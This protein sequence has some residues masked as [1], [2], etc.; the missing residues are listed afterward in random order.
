M[1]SG[2][3]GEPKAHHRSLHVGEPEHPLVR[4][5]VG[6]RPVGRLLA[7]DRTGLHER[8]PA[9]DPNCRG[10]DI[11][12]DPPL[13]GLEQ[14]VVVQLFLEAEV[15]VGI[16][17]DDDGERRVLGGGQLIQPPLD[18]GS[19][20]APVEGHHLPVEVID[21]AEP[22]V[23]LVG[24]LGEAHVPVEGTLEQGADRRGLEEDVRLAAGMQV[25]MPHRLDVQRADPALVDAHSVASVRAVFDFATSR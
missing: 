3:G 1:P 18:V 12:G 16:E 15:D 7:R 5:D 11:G 19:V 20:E 21:G 25:G 8:E 14:P 22:G 24:K 4:D 9:V 13:D 6:E 2:V 17:G 23:P 10:G